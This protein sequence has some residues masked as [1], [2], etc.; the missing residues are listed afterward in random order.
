MPRRG[1]RVCTVPGCPELTK[2][3]YCDGHRRAAD[4]ARGTAAQR[5]YG[6]RHRNGFRTGVLRRNP[7]CV[8]CKR[9]RATVADHW[10]LSRRQLVARRLDPNNPKHGRGLCKPCHDH[11]TARLQPGGFNA[12]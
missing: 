2:G 3:G 7:T 1:L 6:G 9:R 5:G 12:R 11:E 8:L 10:P 4:K